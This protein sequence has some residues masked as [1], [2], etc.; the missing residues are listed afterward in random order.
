MTGLSH[1]QA[2]S[3]FHLSVLLGS[4]LACWQALV[5]RA[6]ALQ[7][8]QAPFDIGQVLRSDGLSVQ[9]LQ[10]RSGALVMRVGHQRWQLFPSPQALWV[11][12]HLQL[13]E[14]RQTI[15]GKWLGFKPSAPQRRWLQKHGAGVRFVGL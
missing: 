15:T 12:Q 4:V 14:P 10:P 9:R 3:G 13:S 6:E 8:V 7:Q 11:L 1:A 2:A 5:H